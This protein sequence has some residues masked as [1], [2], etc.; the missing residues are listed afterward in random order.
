MSANYFEIYFKKM[1]RQGDDYRTTNIVKLQNLC[2]KYMNVHCETFSTFLIGLKLHNKM[3]TKNCKKEPRFWDCYWFLI[4]VLTNAM[5]R[6]NEHEKQAQNK[7]AE[8]F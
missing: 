8:L 3:L 6:K 7:N 4:Y 2:G 1:N 5:P